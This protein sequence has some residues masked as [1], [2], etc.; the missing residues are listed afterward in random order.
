[1][2]KGSGKKVVKV[3]DLVDGENPGADT[4]IAMSLLLDYPVYERL[5]KLA[6]EKRKPMRQYI[7]RGIDKILKLEK[8]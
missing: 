5:R 6:F 2:R 3:A 4:V 8:Y 7:I 1:M